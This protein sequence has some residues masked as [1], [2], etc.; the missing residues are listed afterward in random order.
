MKRLIYITL[1]TLLFVTNS[2]ERHPITCDY[3]GMWQLKHIQ[4]A[5]GTV[6]PCT[7]TYYIMQLHLIKLAF[8]PEDKRPG[9]EMTYYVG[10][11]NHQ[12]DSLFIGDFRHFRN[13]EVVTTLE[14]LER[15]GLNQAETRFKVKTLDDSELI[16]HS[17]FST[18]YFKKF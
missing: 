16:L 7:L 2:C 5:D 6:K 13:E 17:D 1:F 18:L 10:Y 14:E 12:G 8:S 11:M 4:Y 15:F 9:A 3:Q